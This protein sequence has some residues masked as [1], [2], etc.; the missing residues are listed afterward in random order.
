[1]FPNNY[2]LSSC[3]PQIKEL[4]LLRRDGIPLE[5]DD[6][7][8]VVWIITDDNIDTTPVTNYKIRN[9]ITVLGTQLQSIPELRRDKIDGITNDDSILHGKKTEFGWCHDCGSFGGWIYRILPEIG[10]TSRMSLEQ[11][12]LTLSRPVDKDDK[13][14]NTLWLKQII[15]GQDNAATIG[16]IKSSCLKR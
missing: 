1:M 12:S 9:N 8:Y 11:I 15:I 6:I 16:A 4:I 13:K 14:T 7:N 3:I 10:D 5:N 2:K